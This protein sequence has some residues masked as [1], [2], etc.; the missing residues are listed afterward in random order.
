MLLEKTEASQSVYTVAR[1]SAV[2]GYM[3]IDSTI[4]G[5]SRGGLRMHLDV[6]ELEIR[7]LAHSMTLKCGFL[8]QPQGGGKAGLR[9]DP[10]APLTERRRRLAA[11]GQ[12]IAPMLLNRTYIPG[13]DMGTT[14][15]GPCPDD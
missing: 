10:E 7:G 14:R 13:P 6:S 1:G 4:G 11:F 2:M 12:A 9:F 3:V 8:G 5:S 15:V